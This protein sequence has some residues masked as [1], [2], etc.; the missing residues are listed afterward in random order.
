MW[1]PMPSLVILVFWMLTYGTKVSPD[2]ERP[3]DKPE[4][5]SQDD[6]DGLLEVRIG[7]V[8]ARRPFTDGGNRSNC[9]QAHPLNYSTMM[10]YVVITSF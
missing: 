8:A 1:V 6:D 2:S 9:P 5:S 10:R 3:Q 4:T 7:T